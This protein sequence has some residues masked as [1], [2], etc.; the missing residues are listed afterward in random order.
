MSGIIGGGRSRSNIIGTVTSGTLGS[1]VT[2]PAGHVIGR[3]SFQDEDAS[4]VT[5]SSSAYTNTGLEVVHTTTASSTDSY[6]EYQF[7]SGM[8]YTSL[9]NKRGQLDCCMTDSSDS[10][11]S[12]GNSISTG[13][14]CHFQKSAIAEMYYPVYWRALCGL[15]T[16]MGVSSDKGTWNAG[17]T[18]YFRAFV[19]VDGGEFRVIHN[20]TQVTITVTEHRR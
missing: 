10:T 12:D 18:L 2:F 9:I 17:D 19:R 5:T 4:V 6:I 7:Y 15:E 14:H 3:S 11:Y 20:N 8:S 13:L 16:G 1:G